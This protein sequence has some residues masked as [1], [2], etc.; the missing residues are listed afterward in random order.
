MCGHCHLELCSGMLETKNRH[1]ARLSRTGKR[2][3]NENG[4]LKWQSGTSKRKI[5]MRSAMWPGLGKNVMVIDNHA[6]NNVLFFLFLKLL[7]LFKHQV[8]LYLRILEKMR[9]YDKGSRLSFSP[10][11]FDDFS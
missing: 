8:K 2:T 5:E 6:Y 4:L 1:E 10:P 11:H 7:I 3:K 9:I